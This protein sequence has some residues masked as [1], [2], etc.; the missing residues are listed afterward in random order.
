MDSL[1]RWGSWASIAG[2][3]IAIGVTS[4]TIYPEG[5]LAILG[6]G[7]VALL[8]YVLFLQKQLREAG[9]P[10]DT[11]EAD[12]SL[13]NEFLMLLPPNEYPVQFLREHDWGSQYLQGPLKNFYTYIQ[14]WSDPTHV[15]HDLQLRNR[16]RALHAL[17]TE[18]S[19]LIGVHVF[20]I[21]RFEEATFGVYPDES[22][23]TRTAENEYA[24]DAVDSLNEKS[25][26]VVRAYDDFVL[27]CRQ[28]LGK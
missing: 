1:T 20:H 3:A 9:P 4:A 23:H 19:E 21:D 11:L 28:R 18:L 24:F 25:D 7:I 10:L 13:F 26:E 2:L 12:R 17:A 5:P 16:E 27:L 14:R 22:R 6:I 15:F 8:G